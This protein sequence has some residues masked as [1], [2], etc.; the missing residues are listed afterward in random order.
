MEPTKIAGRLRQFSLHWKSIT[1]DT[2]ILNSVTEYRIEFEIG[3]PL[4]LY[5]P[6][7]LKFTDQEQSVIDNEINKLVNKGVI[8]KTSHCGKEFISTIFIRPK[9]DGSYRLILNL[10]NLNEHFK[11]DTLQSAVRLITQNCYMASVD[12][13]DAYYLFLYIENIENI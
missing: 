8:V 13:R 5:A 7:V 2:F 4:Q 12:L 1:S 6:R 11:M 10:K 9:N 3:E